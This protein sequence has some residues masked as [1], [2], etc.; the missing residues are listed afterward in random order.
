MSLLAIDMIAYVENATESTTELLEIISEFTTVAGYKINMQKS[1]LNLYTSS[2]N[3]KMKWK[4]TSYNSFR[5]M[6]YVGIR[7]ANTKHTQFWNI[8]KINKEDLKK[9]VRRLGVVLLSVS[10]NHW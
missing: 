5:N 1:F 9:W 3:Q 6:N 8:T 2:K 10:P 4:C 7:C